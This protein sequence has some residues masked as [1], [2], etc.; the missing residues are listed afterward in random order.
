MFDPTLPQ[1]L[2]PVDAAQ[3]RS[4]FNGL[5]DLIDAINAINAAQVD[6]VSTLDPGEPATASVTVSANSLLFSF[7]IPR[8]DVGLTGNDGNDGDVG[9]P[10]ANAVVDSVTTL[11]AGDPATV[12]VSFDG[13]LVHF[14]FGLPAGGDGASGMDGAAGEVTNVALAGAINGTSSNSNAVTTLDTPFVNDP[15]T[16]ADMEVM[17]AAYNDLVLTLR[18]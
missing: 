1:E 5:K 9:P 17:R 7:G 12:S 13:T 16:L 3:M 6:A 15:P 18:R 10:F 11:P 2:T 4:Q 8:G 14:V